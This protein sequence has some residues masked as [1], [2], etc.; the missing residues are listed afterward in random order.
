MVA[1]FL[2][3]SFWFDIKTHTGTSADIP[4]FNITFSI[5]IT[6]DEILTWDLHMCNLDFRVNYAWRQSEISPKIVI[7]LA[8]HV[9]IRPTMCITSCIFYVFYHK[10]T[11]IEYV[12]FICN[13]NQ[14]CLSHLCSGV[15]FRSGH[16]VIQTHVLVHW[17]A[18][19]LQREDLPSRG[20]VR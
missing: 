8:S 15:L 11:I 17:H 10:I 19:E 13:H 6:M 7:T 14:Y 5:L 2:D 4:T 16:Q 3:L 18:A 12:L 9:R 1:L 20:A